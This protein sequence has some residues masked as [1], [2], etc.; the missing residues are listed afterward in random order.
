MASSQQPLYQGQVPQQHQNVGQQR[1]VPIGQQRQQALGQAQ[2]RPTQSQEQPLNP[3]AGYDPQLA[4]FILEKPKNAKSWEDAEPKRQNFS[5]QEIQSELHKSRRNHGN[6]K[7]NMDEIPSPNCRRIINEL[8]EDK[9]VE[10][11]KYNRAIQYRI[12][13][14]TNTWRSINRRDRQLVRVDIILETEPSGFQ[15]PMQAKVAV[16]AG[17]QDPNKLKQQGYPQNQQFP[18]QLN[19]SQN[20][21]QQHQQRPPQQ[22]QQQQ[23]YP[24]QQNMGHSQQVEPPRPQHPPGQGNMNQTPGPGNPPPPPPPPGMPGPHDMGGPPRPP[25]HEGGG[26]PMPGPMQHPQPHHP[27][28]GQHP[29][30]GT[31]PEQLLMPSNHMRHG[32]GRLV[33]ILNPNHRR[34]QKARH[35]GHRDAFGSSSDSDS[36]WEVESEDSSFVNIEHDDHGDAGR[37]ERGRQQHNKKLKKS[38][39]HH[40]LSR[41]REHSRSHSQNR[42]RRNNADSHAAKSTRRHRASNLVDDLRNGRLSLESFT[43]DSF[44]SS[45]NKIPGHMTPVHIHLSTNNIAEDRTRNGNASPADLYNEKKKPGKHYTAHDMARES[46]NSSSEHGSGTESLNTTSAHT[47]NDGIWDR[48]IRRRPCFKHVHSRRKSFYGDKPQPVFDQ[49]HPSHIYDDDMDYRRAQKARYPR[50]PAHDYPQPR[51]PR[52]Y[53]HEPESYFDDHPTH[54]IRLNMQHRRATMANP[55]IIHNPYAQID[56]PPKPIRSSSYLDRHDPDYMVPQPRALADGEEPDERFGLS[57]FHAALDHIQEKK[58]MRH[59]MRRPN[60]MG[61]R[62]SAFQYEDDEWNVRVPLGGRW[63]DYESY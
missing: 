44:R 61:R 9:N 30:P 8:V 56:F 49:P 25:M 52:A 21:P 62:D 5:L 16:S 35:K 40:S 39:K 17:P 53:L 29:I 34:H 23:P 36:S 20:M 15:E 32:Q 6:V 33:D 37:R 59:L 41:A 12:A 4:S 42:T 19:P 58:D 3:Y 26:R 24:S 63:G 55:P 2:Q 18:N 14:V 28:P 50:E 47:A 48:P 13:S 51:S 45:H 38:Q 54:P 31:F 1:Q 43:T 11:A 57:D 60:V 7:K 10:L 27:P 46:S 22:Q